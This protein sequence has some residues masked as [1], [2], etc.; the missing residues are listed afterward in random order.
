MI[1]DV[2]AP[3][4]LGCRRVYTATEAKTNTA[5]PTTSQR[6]FEKRCRTA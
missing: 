1:T 5:V 6:R 3:N 2:E 4:T